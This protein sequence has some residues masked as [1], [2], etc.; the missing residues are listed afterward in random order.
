MGTHRAHSFILYLFYGCFHKAAE[1][2]IYERDSVA[3]KA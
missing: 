3:R 1:L 2:S